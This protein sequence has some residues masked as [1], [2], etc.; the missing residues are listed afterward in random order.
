MDLGQ[1]L[2]DFIAVLGIS[3]S[4]FSRSLGFSP[5]YISRIIGGV[6]KKP[7]ERFFE[8]VRR[9]Y[10]VNINWLKTG[11][12]IMFNLEDVSSLAKEYD[13]SK[14]LKKY[15]QLPLPDRR[16]ID[17]I[18]NAMLVKNQVGQGQGKQ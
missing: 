7:S 13:L 2:D 16:V 14:L 4:E 8:A 9:E 15:S 12:G 10:N 5:A 3:K 17:H 18:M 11:T 1:R 6:Q